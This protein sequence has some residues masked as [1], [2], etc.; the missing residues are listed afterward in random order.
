LSQT[1][2]VI[3]KSLVSFDPFKSVL[4]SRLRISNRTSIPYKWDRCR[5]FR[6]RRGD[7]GCAAPI[8][9][10]ARLPCGGATT[11]AS[12]YVTRAGY[13]SSCTGSIGRW[14]CERMAYRRG[15]ESPRRRRNRTPDRLREITKPAPRPRLLLPQ[16]R[17][18]TNVR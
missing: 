18:S 12:R 1:R 9:A 6:P 13:T 8:A 5:N 17:K 3:S 4:H 10:L 2:D 11:R 7:S 14:P 15:R 16:V